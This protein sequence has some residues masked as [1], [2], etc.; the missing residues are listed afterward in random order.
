M[1]DSSDVTGLTPEQEGLVLDLVQFGLDVAGI[2]EPTP[3][4]DGSNAL[5]SLGRSDWM[6]AGLSAVGML[7]YF[8]DLAKLRRLPGHERALA[9]ALEMARKDARFAGYLRPALE[10][11]KGLLDDVPESMLPKAI[12][13][14]RDRIGKFLGAIRVVPGP[15]K[16]AAARLPADLQPGFMRA[17]KQP[18]MRNPRLLRKHPGPVS[19]DVL[20]RELEQKGFLHV[21]RGRHGAKE[22][23]DVWVRR[24]FKD[25]ED[26][27]EAVRID[28]RPQKPPSAPSAANRGEIQAGNRPFVREH[29]T[30]SRTSTSAPPELGGKLR[31]DIEGMVVELG[32]GARKGDYSH[33]HHEGF[34]ASPDNLERYLRGPLVGTRKFDP[35][36]MELPARRSGKGMLDPDEL[37]RLKARLRQRPRR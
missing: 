24:V 11:L 19:E 1:V 27:F 12:A 37:A 5:L 23:S 25:G 13:G 34:P 14:I 29:H 35:V 8:G 15:L 9:R 30:L 4:A 18:P 28:R 2:F 7:P 32:R 17:M 6:G 20:V 33:W 16:K 3:V 36:G 26:T 22:D 21:K 10:R 31:T